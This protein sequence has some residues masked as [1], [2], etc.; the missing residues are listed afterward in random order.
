M[1]A[2]ALV[3]EDGFSKNGEWVGCFEKNEFQNWKWKF[4]RHLQKIILSFLAFVHWNGFG[5]NVEYASPV[6]PQN[7]IK[8]YAKFCVY[9]H[10][11]FCCCSF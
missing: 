10:V 11:H 5:T 3:V 4:Q 2:V 1:S 7:L 6:F 8:L 9:V